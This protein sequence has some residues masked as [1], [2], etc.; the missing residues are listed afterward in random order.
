MHRFEYKYPS[1]N[2]T[3]GQYCFLSKIRS[4]NQIQEELVAV[5]RSQSSLRLDYTDRLRSSIWGKLH[6]QNGVKLREVR[7]TRNIRFGYYCLPNSGTKKLSSLHTYSQHVIYDVLRWGQFLF[8]DNIWADFFPHAVLQGRLGFL[9]CKK[10]L[11]KMLET[12]PPKQFFANSAL[13]RTED[14]REN[15]FRKIGPHVHN[16]EK[17]FP[18]LLH[19]TGLKPILAGQARP[20]LFL[21]RNGML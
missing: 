8:L 3:Y 7:N 13:S 17:N 9:L 12:I 2:Q 16:F 1:C 4:G 5:R 14:L 18:S 20:V 6:E 10:W 21:K 11:L 15:F 19:K